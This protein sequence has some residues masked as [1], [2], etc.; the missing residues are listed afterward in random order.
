MAQIYGMEQEEFDELP[1]GVQASVKMAHEQAAEN[2]KLTERIAELEKTTKPV[3][4]T[5]V[6]E[7]P[8][9]HNNWKLEPFVVMGYETR[10]DQLLDQVQNGVDKKLAVAV[11]KYRTEILELLNQNHPGNWSNP[12]FIQSAVNITVGKHLTEILAEVKAGTNDW[13]TETGGGAGNNNDPNAAKNYDTLLSDDQKKAAKNFGLTNEMYYNSL[14][15]MG[16]L[17]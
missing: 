12:A 5:E 10:R 11:R 4:V 13:F 2:I 7:N 3:V 1:K 16:V 15:E 8:G 6:N 17:S 14:K 9:P